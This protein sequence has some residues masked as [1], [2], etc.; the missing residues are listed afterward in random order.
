MCQKSMC[1]SLDIGIMTW[2]HWVGE[3]LPR[4]VLAEHFYPKRF[5]Y[6]LL[7]DIYNQ[8][9]PRNVWNSIYDTIK[10]AGVGKDRILY[11]RFDRHYHFASL[12]GVTN[13]F[14]GYSFHPKVLDVLRRTYER[15]SSRSAGRRI[16][17]LRTGSN[18]RNIANLHEIIDVLK[19]CDVEFIEVGKLPFAE[20]VALFSSAEQA[21]GVLASGLTGLFFSPDHVKVLSLAPERYENTFFYSIIRHRHGLMPPVSEQLPRG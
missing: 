12:H 8:M 7:Q 4:L 18:A 6:V 11:A 3:I 13:T 15:F 20:Q 5:R 16:A 14:T 9:A 10:M 1:L 21:V 2:G 19:A 17:L